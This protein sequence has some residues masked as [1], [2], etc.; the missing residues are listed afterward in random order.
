MNV[1]A[2]WSAP[3]PTPSFSVGASFNLRDGFVAGIPS[4]LEME[5]VVLWR[6]PT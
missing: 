4:A 5:V 3:A 1:D 6:R 2:S